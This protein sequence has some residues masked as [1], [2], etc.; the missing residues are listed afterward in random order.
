G[1]TIEIS[2]DIHIDIL[3]PSQEQK[4]AYLK[5]N[6]GLMSEAMNSESLAV[7]ITYKDFSAM[8]CG[9]MYQNREEYL[10][11]KYGPEVLDVDLMKANHHGTDVG[12]GKKWAQATT[13]RVAVAMYGYQ[14]A[15]TS[16]SNYADTGAYVFAEYFDGYIR[17]VSDGESYCDV[18]R[19]KQRTT[20]LY[21]YYD[22]TAQSIYPPQN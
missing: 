5:L 3:N 17:V 8:F 10:V 16:Y 14:M 9:D 22:M 2:D 7:K 4:E 20:N 11:E 1:D 6:P 18:T 15:G 12:N 19:S 13:P 21:T